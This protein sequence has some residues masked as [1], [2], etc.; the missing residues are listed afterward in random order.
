MLTN[1]NWL[2][3]SLIKFLLLLVAMIATGYG[4][5]KWDTLLVHHV[6][7]VF[8]SAFMWLSFK[9]KRCTMT[10]HD[11]HFH[12][13]GCG[14]IDPITELAV[15]CFRFW[16]CTRDVTYVRHLECKWWFTV[17]YAFALTWLLRP[18]LKKKLKDRNW[19]VLK[20]TRNGQNSQLWHC[21][22]IL[23][24]MD[25]WWLRDCL[26]VCHSLVNWVS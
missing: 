5:F 25:W 24:S 13:W 2:L 3:S 20:E 17:Y 19:K 6:L 10:S 22:T 7:S 26:S 15:F 21:G 12:R 18:A 16:K 14:W 4:T 9:V 1:L 8:T 23:R 11:G